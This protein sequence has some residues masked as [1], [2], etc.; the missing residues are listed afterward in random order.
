MSTDYTTN[1][2]A[3]IQ[4]R[5]DLLD[6]NADQ[7]EILT[8]VS[9]LQTRVNSNPATTLQTN[10]NSLVTIQDEIVQANQDL[11]IAKDRAASLHGSQPSYYESWFPI[12]RPL[13]KQTILIL[14]VIGIFFFAL[15]FFMLISTFGFML[16]LN[17][18]W[19]TDENIA[20]VKALFPYGIGFIIVA[21][22]ILTIVGWLR[23]P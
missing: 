20:R 10:I 3:V 15:A 13:R 5:L 4:K 1:T 2:P 23:K 21:L 11:Q 19:Y 9:A 16:H 17:I 7:A 22:L 6:P 12:N 8:A 14:L 18:T